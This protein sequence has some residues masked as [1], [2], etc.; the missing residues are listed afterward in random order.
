MTRRS[1][2]VLVARTSANKAEKVRPCISPA[3]GHYHI[4]L[5]CNYKLSYPRA[6]PAA[7][8]RDLLCVDHSH[9]QIRISK[10]V[11]ERQSANDTFLM[12][13][14]LDTRWKQVDTIAGGWSID[15]QTAPFQYSRL[16]VFFKVYVKLRHD[17]LWH[18]WNGDSKC[19]WK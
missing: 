4:M 18:N 3:T 1:W 5:V 11:G 8:R 14:I 16:G 13:W 17:I 7:V 9:C 2:G 6:N 15:S 12:R 19:E 10:K